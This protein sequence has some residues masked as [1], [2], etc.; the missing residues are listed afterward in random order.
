MIEAILER[1]NKLSRRS[2]GGS[3]EEQLLATNLDILFLVTSLN[4]DLNPSRLERFLA[5]ADLTGCERV[6]LLTKCD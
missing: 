2:A 6:L 1:T 3:G 5:A 4:R